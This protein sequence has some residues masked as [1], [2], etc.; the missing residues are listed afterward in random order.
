MLSVLYAFILYIL[1][2]GTV[3]NETSFFVILSI[4]LI[5][6]GI[7]IVLRRRRQNDDINQTQS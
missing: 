6:I 1:P 3:K 4:L 7:A 2:K 5:L